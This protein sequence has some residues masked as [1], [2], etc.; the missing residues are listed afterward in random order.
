MAK[1]AS[2]RTTNGADDG[3]RRLERR[4]A[5]AAPL[6]REPLGPAH[7]GEGDPEDDL[8]GRVPEEIRREGAE[9][10]ELLPEG[11]RAAL[12]LRVPVHVRV[13]HVLPPVDLDAVD[14]AEDERQDGDG[15]ARRDAQQAL[16]QG[17]PSPGASATRARGPAPAAARHR[18]SIASTWANAQRSPSAPTQR[19]G[20]H[21]RAQHGARHEDEGPGRDASS[22]GRS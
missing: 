2:V 12:E 15:G 17:A 8:I 5:R 9:P 1:Y 13:P 21:R 18:M 14:A 20:E 3:G 4:L 22:R 11:R 7:D 6:P 19:D 10:E 16:A